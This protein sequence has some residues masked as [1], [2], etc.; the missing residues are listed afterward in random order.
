MSDR[1]SLVGVDFEHP[2]WPFGGNRQ[3]PGGAPIA[4]STRGSPEIAEQSPPIALHVLVLTKEQ[5]RNT[6]WFPVHSPRP[7]HVSISHTRVLL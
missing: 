3:A 5:E 7:S 1:A 6:V 4:G 2:P